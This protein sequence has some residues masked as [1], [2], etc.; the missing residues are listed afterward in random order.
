MQKSTIRQSILP[1]NHSFVAVPLAVSFLNKEP[2]SVNVQIKLWNQAPRN[3]H[4]Q[5]TLGY[6]GQ[7]Q[8]GLVG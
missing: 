6:P 1:S 8:Q 3:H 2:D 5:A 7:Y 4:K